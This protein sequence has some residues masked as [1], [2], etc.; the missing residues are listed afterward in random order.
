MHSRIDHLVIGAGDLVQGVEYVKDCLG[1]DIPFGGVHTKMGTHNHLMSLD[2]DIFL[3]VIAVNPDMKS[4]ESPRWFG[5]D[6]PHIRQQIRVKPALL[7]WV[8]NTENIDRL[9]GQ[10]RFSFGKAQLIHR[11]NLS[12]YFGLPDDG[13]LL[14]GGMLPYVL[15][16]QTDFHPSKKMADTGCRIQRL[17]IYHSNPIWF[18]SVLTSIGAENLADVHSLPENSP[19]YLV[20][21]VDTP[22]GVKVLSS[23]GESWE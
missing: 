21:Y 19:P 12:W 17:E 3:E 16:W 18:Q 2:Q 20:A 11:G 7:T 6:D 4:P 13:R 22:K 23:L 1:V 10:T 14:A 8:V 9:L 15:E 5:L